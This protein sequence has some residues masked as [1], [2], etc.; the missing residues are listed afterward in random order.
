MNDQTRLAETLTGT[1]LRRPGNVT[2]PVRALFKRVR[3]FLEA[4][5][6]EAAIDE[7]T[8]AVSLYPDVASL[9]RALATAYYRAG[10][11][12]E[13]EDAFL[14]AIK[15]APCASAFHGLGLTRLALRRREAALTALRRAVDHDPRRWSSWL[16]IAEVTDDD[17]ERSKAI[18]AA[19]DIL[20]QAVARDPNKTDSKRQLARLFVR[21]DRVGE[22]IPLLEKALEDA[23]D[24]STAYQS[25]ARAHAYIGNFEEAVQYQKCSI[26]TLEDHQLGAAASAY[27][28]A[29]AQDALTAAKTALDH[30]DISFFLV[31]GTLLGCVRDG[32]PL[33]HDRDVD[34]GIFSDV[35]NRDILAALRQDPGFVLPLVVADDAP[36]LPLSFKGVALDVFKHDLQDGATWFGFSRRSGDIGWRLTPFG[37]ED[38]AVAGQSFCI[39]SPATAYLNELYGNWRQPDKGFSSVISSPAL[40]ELDTDVKTFTA[41]SRLRLAIVRGDT[42]RIEVLSGLLPDELRT[43]ARRFNPNG[44]KVYGNPAG[45]GMR[46]KMSK[47]R[48]Y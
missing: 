18:D 19:L 9:R 24:R 42:A 44:K 36:Y 48:I 28:V 27:S 14:Q 16:S 30:A 26:E 33:R 43:L 46:S 5:N 8:L 38:M 31:A 41:L 29:R 13:S 34:I 17:T 47:N 11:F 21:I 32:A 39:P 12:A 7:L 20:K 4:G 40:T 15:C 1:P 22:A 45:S 37:L 25:L 35:P 3:A 2:A 23:A 6:P 10:A